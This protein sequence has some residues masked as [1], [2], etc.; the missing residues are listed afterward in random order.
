MNLSHG[1]IQLAQNMFV[2]SATAQHQL[3][4][5]GQTRDGRIFRYCKMGA[6]DSV[7]GKLYQSAATIAGHQSLANNTTSALAAGATS[8]TVTCASS[9]AANFYSEG[10][11]CIA[12]SAG[13]GYLYSIERHAAVST[14]ASGQFFFYADDTVQVALLPASIITLM[15]NPYNAVVVVPATTATALVVGVSPYIITAS[16]FGWLQTWGSCAVLSNDA[17]ALGQWVN[18]IAASCGRVAGMS[19]P[20]VT[21]CYIVGQPVGKMMQ[22]GVAGQFT[23]VFLTI[24][25]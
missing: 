4:A 16:Q 7:A 25:P 13:Q 19:S 14:G 15:A 9:V 1:Y 24:C 2:S 10:Y 5:V 12:S 8:I 22:T 6:V 3:G 20:A 11:A 21:A 17:S 23:V 18:G